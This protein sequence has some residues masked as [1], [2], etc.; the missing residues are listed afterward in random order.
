MPVTC[1]LYADADRRAANRDVL[2]LGR[3]RR[4]KT[5]RQAM[6]DDVLECRQ[7]LYFQRV[8]MRIEGNDLVELAER[9]PTLGTSARLIPEQVRDRRL[10]EPELPAPAIPGLEKLGFLPRVVRGYFRRL[11]RRRYVCAT[12]ESDSLPSA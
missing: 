2:E 9:N 1:R 10:C 4:Q 5:Q 6:V 12:P 7:P 3:Y 8:R 11:R